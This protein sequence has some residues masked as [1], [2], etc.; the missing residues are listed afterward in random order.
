MTA[1]ENDVIMIGSIY[2]NTGVQ[3]E[4]QSETSSPST[5]LFQPINRD[6]ASK[7][8][9]TD[10][11]TSN[12]PPPVPQTV[13]KFYTPRNSNTH[14]LPPFS[15]HV[16]RFPPRHINNNGAI[17]S[18]IRGAIQFLEK[19]GFSKQSSSMTYEE[20]LPSLLGCSIPTLSSARDK[21]PAPTVSG[22]K[23]VAKKKHTFSKRK[24]TS[25]KRRVGSKTTIICPKVTH[26]SI[27]INKN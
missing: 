19:V 8:T 18:A 13:S 16:D 20:E 2:K 24:K 14:L 25:S 11:V 15:L 26:I 4:Q 23:K 6:L 22:P 5:L 21:S 9:N 27:N 10:P 12:S 3:H 17:V 1:S 7:G